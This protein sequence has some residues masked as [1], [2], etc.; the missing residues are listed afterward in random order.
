MP[1]S[2]LILNYE[3]PPLGG[4]AGIITK[5]LANEFT[6]LGHRVTVLTTLFEGQEALET[7]GD[8]TIIR[9]PSK[10]ARMDR[11]NIREMYSYMTLAISYSKRNFSVGQ[12]DVCI[13]NFVLPGGYVAVQLK[14]KLGLPFFIIS[15]GHD[16]PW[17]YPR[18]MFFL[19]FFFYPVLKRVCNTA[20]NIVVLTNEMKKIAYKFLGPSHRDKCLIIPNGIHKSNLDA[21]PKPKDKLRILFVGRLVD[22]KDPMLFMHTMHLLGVKG[23]AYDAIVLGGGPLRKTMEQFKAENGLDQVTIKGKVSHNEVIDYMLKSH[24]LLAPS[25]HEAMSVSILEAL[26]LGLYIITTPISGNK[27]L[28]RHNGVLVDSRHPEAFLKEVIDF[29]ET[30]FDRE[31]A[32][33]PSIPEDIL[34]NYNWRV[35]AGKYINLIDAIV[36]HY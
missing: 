16:I 9:L 36:D 24:I 27:E 19:H 5:H 33:A 1:Y 15:H 25:K 34:Q 11:S 31:M 17:F 10:R 12:F 7:K 26:S 30:T 29:K 32:T 20:D 3:Y 21:P 35:V 8:L 22:Q 2:I 28:V 14:R 23:V 13:A 6:N 4:G 18:Q